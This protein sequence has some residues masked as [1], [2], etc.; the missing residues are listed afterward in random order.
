MV[1]TPKSGLFAGRFERQA[2]GEDMPQPCC[3]CD[4]PA[5]HHFAVSYRGQVLRGAICQEHG[6]AVARER[7]GLHDDGH[8]NLGNTKIGRALTD[9]KTTPYFRRIAEPEHQEIAAPETGRSRFDFSSENRFSPRRRRAMS[10][11]KY[12][13]SRGS[14][15]KRDD[16]G[17]DAID[18]ELV[19]VPDT[20]HQSRATHETGEMRA[21]PDTSL[22]IDP[23]IGN[24]SSLQYTAEADP[25]RVKIAD[26][27]KVLDKY[28]IPL[29]TGEKKAD[30]LLRQHG[31]SIVRTAL[32]AAIKERRALT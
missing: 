22:M 11:S 27:I 32:R 28:A 31:E 24:G 21:T 30:Q 13:L 4:R 3:C 1:Q 2:E 15:G 17:Q 5:T 7:L 10:R 20:A 14:S 25:S 6:N 18:S 16:V 9:P 12:F 29:E 19:M 26:T 8:R 23:Q